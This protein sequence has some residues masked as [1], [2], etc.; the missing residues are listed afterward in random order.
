MTYDIVLGRVV[1][2]GGQPQISTPYLSDSWLWDGSDWTEA[3][4]STSPPPRKSQL[5]VYD[6]LRS[7][8]VLFGG[9][10]AGSLAPPTLGDTWV[11]GIAGGIHEIA[12]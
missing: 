6:A 4:P 3:F 2:F 7:Q 11:Y 9:E 8:V 12:P 1:L 5:M 10:Q